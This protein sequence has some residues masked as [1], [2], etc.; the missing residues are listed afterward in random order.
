MSR[1]VAQRRFSRADN[2]FGVLAPVI[3]TP[4]VL[5]NTSTRALIAES[6]RITSDRA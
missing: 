1:Q 3:G 4:A 6:S 2:T 5:R